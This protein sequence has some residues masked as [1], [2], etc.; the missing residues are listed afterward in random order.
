MEAGV[1]R[2]S[3]RW[4]GQ[5]TA[6][7]KSNGLN[8]RFAGLASHIGEYAN[9]QASTRAVSLVRILIVLLVLVKWGED[10]AFFSAAAPGLVLISPLFFLCCTLALVGWRTKPAIL[11]LSIILALF[12][13]GYGK[14][15][16]VHE[17]AH[18]HS[19]ML[20][21]V[22]ALL[23]GAPCEKSYSIDRWLALKRA[24]ACGTPAPKERGFTWAQDLIVLQMGALYC[25]TAIDK[26]E[27]RFLNGERLERIFEWAYGGHPAYDFLTQ[28]WLLG[29][30]STS[31][32]IIEY[33]LAFSVIAKRFKRPT[34]IIALCLHAAFYFLLKVDTYSATM[35]VLYLLYADPDRLHRAI[36]ALHGHAAPALGRAA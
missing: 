1:D 4:G 28:P 14:V 34:F 35:I 31:V 25:W 6:I 13:F 21:L 33:F 17:W 20:F 12:Y 30:A 22:V 15:L 36:D 16:G 5:V 11:G 8:D 26:T 27:W 32:V 10:A 23:N 3:L 18:H 19:Y 24:S 7:A 9:R 2:R 29:L